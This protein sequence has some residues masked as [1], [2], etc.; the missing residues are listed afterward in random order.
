MRKN[1]PALEAFKLRVETAKKL[2]PLG[3]VTGEKGNRSSIVQYKMNGH[4]HHSY[5][6]YINTYVAMLY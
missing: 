4:V 2:I 5:T 1:R 3:L 6:S